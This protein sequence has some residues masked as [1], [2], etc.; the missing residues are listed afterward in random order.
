MSAKGCGLQ[1]GE[2]GRSPGASSGGMRRRRVTGAGFVLRLV[3]QLGLERGKLLT[4]ARVVSLFAG[5]EST[6]QSR[7]LR[8]AGRRQQV[9][10]PDLAVV[11][12]KVLNL[13]KPLLQQGPEH[14]VRL[15][16]A[17]AQS[18]CEF[19]LRTHW[20]SRDLP[21]GGELEL[22]GLRDARPI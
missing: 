4:Q 17:D 2:A 19:A 22:V 7:L 15:A 13:D 16:H 10:V 5:D 1:G 12:A 18:R 21:H 8:H 9:E 6:R 3:S 14:E 20:L 11:A